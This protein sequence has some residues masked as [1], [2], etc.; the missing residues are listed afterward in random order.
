MPA[1]H[2]GDRPDAPLATE[3]SGNAR[4]QIHTRVTV[5]LGYDEFTLAHP[6]A[7]KNW[8]DPDFGM[9]DTAHSG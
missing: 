2:A 1:R 7:V 8:R 3:I 9:F 4:Y 5:C 6:N